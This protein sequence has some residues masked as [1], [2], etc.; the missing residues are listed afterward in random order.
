MNE[1]KKHFV[2]Q[3]LAADPPSAEARRP[4][5]KEMRTM[6]E[7]TLTR[8]ERR[9][10]LLSAVLMGLMGL[11]VA[12]EGGVNVWIEW[13]SR[14]I[15]EREDLNFIPAIF[16]LTALVVLAVA[17]IQFRAY[18]TG[19]VSRRMSN[20]WAAGAGIAYV[21]LLGGL[22]MLMGHYIPE[23][24]RDDVRVLGVVLMV[25]AAVA[26]MRHRVG[27]AELRTAEKL[28]EIELRLAQI[29]EALEA[30]PRAADPA[31]EQ[32]PPPV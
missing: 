4:Y 18:W 27:Q 1:S 28:L 24:L 9:G 6:F 10:Y 5:E 7:K 32:P 22:F 30:Q 17:G 21:G 13:P 14:A 15:P 26:W 12:I 31:A 8:N 19:I 23:M 11:G 25:Y 29:G 3:L 16:L 20:N 2:D